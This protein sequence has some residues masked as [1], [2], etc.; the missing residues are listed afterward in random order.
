MVTLSN[1]QQYGEVDIMTMGIRFIAE[2]YDIESNEVVNSKI[3]RSDTIK[4]PTT[5]KELPRL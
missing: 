5:L 3:L 1:F 2:Y 4:R